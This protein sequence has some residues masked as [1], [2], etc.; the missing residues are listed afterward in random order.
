MRS[1][2]TL[3]K[4]LTLILSL[5]FQVSAGLGQ[6]PPYAANVTTIRS[7]ANSNITISFKSPVIGTCTTVFASQQ[8]YTGYVSL[9]PYTLAPIQQDYPINTFF[10]FIE[11]RNSPQTAPLTIYINGGP[12]SSSMVGLFQ[13]SGPC[14]VVEIANGQLGTQPRDWGWDRSSNVLY[15]DQPSQVGF[16]YDVLA[17]GSLNL[18]NAAISFPPSNTPQ[19]QPAYTFLNGTFSSNDYQSTANT[20]KIAAYAVWHM[21]QGFLG[22]FPQY[23]PGLRPNS[24]QTSATSVNLFAE[25]YGGKYGPIFATV[26]E[27]QNNGRQNGSISKN[28][29]LEIRLSS[30]GILQGC[31]DDLVQGRFYPIFANNNT[32]GIQAYSTIEE[33][34]AAN[35]Y[36]SAD[37]CQQQIL[38]CR[39][40]VN[41]MDPLD[42]GDV[43]TVNHICHAAE[44]NCNNNVIGPYEASGRDFYDIS[45]MTPDPFP[46]STYLEYL[47]SADVQSSI[48]AVMNYTETSVPVATAFLSTGDYDRGDQISDMAY[49]LSL[50]IR[51]AL[52][53]GDRD[54]I[55]NWLGGEAVSFSIAAQS[56]ATSPFYSAGYAEIVVNSTYVGGVVR[57]YGNL[58]FSRIY[59]SGHLIPAYQP[60]TAFTVFTRIIMGT[61][62][63]TGEPVDLNTFATVGNP[64]ATYQ[65][66]A[67]AQF[68]PKCWIRNIAGSCTQDDV[69]MIKDDDGV[70]INGVLYNSSSEWQPPASSIQLNA[71]MPGT[72]PSSMTATTASTTGKLLA[73]T[74]TQHLPT[75]VYVATNTPTASATKSG[76]SPRRPSIN[77]V[78]CFW[79]CCMI[80]MVVIQAV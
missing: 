42:N 53:Y 75:G 57:Q 71:G 64:N 22:A 73:P 31:V 62:I 51:V 28:N 17:N 76:A 4:T 59:D 37:G 15:I 7:P 48:G 30:L 60:E 58:S 34:N 16:S 78:L 9:P 77:V 35:S 5:L 6:F 52:I 65:N 79:T 27:Q 80:V 23:N 43:T 72:V 44:E 2:Y 47:N 18:L 56:P 20:S 45:Q 70:I 40:A 68:P 3:P 1:F 74:T 14:E 50:G 41:S 32:Y 29:T 36:L 21:L 69:T 12:G 26:W 46:P 39:N 11:A 25:S 13:E 66:T 55:C 10:W 63:S 61:D 67:P 38:A 8:Q 49:L 33:L 19:D 24:S 54:Y